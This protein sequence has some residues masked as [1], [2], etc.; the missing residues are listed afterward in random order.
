MRYLI[1]LILII[2]CCTPYVKEKGIFCPNVTIESEYGV[3]IVELRKVCDCAHYVSQYFSNPTPVKIRYVKKLPVSKH[4]RIKAFVRGNNIFIQLQKPMFGK[5]NI[6]N[7][8]AINMETL[9]L[10][11]LYHFYAKDDDEQNAD[12]FSLE[13]RCP[14]ED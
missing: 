6:A 8:L 4:E 13:H 2:T 1:I 10:H 9:L 11:E 3:D 5:T 12:K 14:K 7:D